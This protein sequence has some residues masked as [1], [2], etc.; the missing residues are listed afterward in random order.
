VDYS[1]WI[2]YAKSIPK[3]KLKSETGLR[4]VIRDIG[5]RVGKNLSEEQVKKLAAQ[6]RQMSKTEN[7]KS[8]LDKL[9]RRGMNKTD[10]DSIKRQIKK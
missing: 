2:N 6:F 9:S 10:L 1:K 4:D 7:T 3:E 5:K 8:V